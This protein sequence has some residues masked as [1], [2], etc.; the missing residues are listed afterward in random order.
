MRTVI[1]TLLLLSVVGLSLTVGYSFAADPNPGFVVKAVI[2]DNDTGARLTPSTRNIGV[3]LIITNQSSTP[4]VLPGLQL[5]RLIL[6]RMEQPLP[7]P[8]ENLP[9]DTEI[10]WP[11]IYMNPYGPQSIGIDGGLSALVRGTV[12]PVTKAQFESTPQKVKTLKA[13]YYFS[14]LTIDTYDAETG[15]SSVYVVTAEVIEVK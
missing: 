11:Y 7:K 14:F 9:Q 10:S 4:L 6:T 13:G 12:L 8:N 2:F 15:I 1:R 3:R 5:S